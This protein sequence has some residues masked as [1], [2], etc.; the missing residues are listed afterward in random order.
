MEAQLT[1]RAAWPA[2]DPARGPVT[3]PR[4]MAAENRPAGHGG[5]RTGSWKPFRPPGRVFHCL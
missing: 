3:S 1:E 4:W 2:V 5:D